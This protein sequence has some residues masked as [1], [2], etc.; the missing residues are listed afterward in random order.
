MSGR[1]GF[2]SATARIACRVVAI[3]GCATACMLQAYGHSSSTAADVFVSGEEG[4]TCYRI[5]VLFRLPNGDIALYAEGRKDNCDDI[6]NTDIVFKLSTDNGLSFGPLHRL[7]GESTNTTKVTIGNPAPVAVNG[8]VLMLCVRNAERLLRLRSYDAAGREWQAKADDITDATFGHLNDRMECKPGALRAGSDLRMA[9]CTIVEATEWCLNSI[10]CSGFTAR[11]PNSSFCQARNSPPSIHQ[12]YFKS[13]AGGN[14]DASWASWTKPN[15]PGTLVATGPPG[16]MVLP[17]GR[18]LS[19][20][21]RYAGHFPEPV[22]PS[23]TRV[24]MFSFGSEWAVR[25]APGAKRVSHR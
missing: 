3:S 4:Y 14:N 24:K 6:Y 20:F 11:A 9:N 10:H 17:S 15:P 2:S 18:I 19:E 1:A 16:G 25:M 22:M 12:F 13:R 5:P 21:Y 23:H 7:Y 8:K